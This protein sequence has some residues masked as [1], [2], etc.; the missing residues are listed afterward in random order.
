MTTYTPVFNLDKDLVPTFKSMT[1]DGA[2]RFEQLI[3]GKHHGFVHNLAKLFINEVLKHKD[4]KNFTFYFSDENFY[5]DFREW[6]Y[7][8]VLKDTGLTKLHLDRYLNDGLNEVR[9]SRTYKDKDIKLMKICFAALK[10]SRKLSSQYIS[11]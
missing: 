2:E 10:N 6:V 4:N 7:E 3:A 11:N 9:L 1:L 5:S 8:E